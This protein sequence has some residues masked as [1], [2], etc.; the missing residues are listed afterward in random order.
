[1]LSGSAPERLRA[2]AVDDYVFT[3]S[4]PI[5][6]HKWNPRITV[7][8]VSELLAEAIMRIHDGRSVS[9]LFA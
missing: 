9:A 4:I 2:A 3:D 7:L 6:E 5:P 8:S 1:V